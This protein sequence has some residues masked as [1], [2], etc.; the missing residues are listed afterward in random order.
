M[1]SNSD[2]TCTVPGCTKTDRVCMR[3]AGVPTDPEAPVK[4]FRDEE[5]G[6]TFCEAFM[7]WVVDSKRF[8]DAYNAAPQ[9][10]EDEGN[11]DAALTPTVILSRLKERVQGQDKACQSIASAIYEQRKNRQLR[12]EHQDLLEELDLEDEDVSKANIF[13]P[14]PT[15]CGKTYIVK[16]VAKLVNEPS[17]VYRGTAGLTAAG[18]VGGNVEDIA[19]EYFGKVQE[20]LEKQGD[21]KAADPRY[22]ANWINTNGGIIAIDE[23]DKIAAS[24]GTGKDVGGQAVQD[25]LLTFMEGEEVNITVPAPGNPRGVQVTIDTTHIQFILM[26]AFSPAGGGDKTGLSQKPLV[27]II[28]ARKGSGGSGMEGRADASGR[29]EDGNLYL[30]AKEED[31]VKFGFKPE[32]VG[33]IMGYFAPLRQL[34]EEDLVRILTHVRGNPVAVEKAR[35]SILGSDRGEAGFDLIFTD[36]ALAAIAKKAAK[37]GTGA[38]GLKTVLRQTL[39]EIGFLAPDMVGECDEILIVPKV[40]ETEGVIITEGEEKTFRK[41]GRRKLVPVDDGPK[42]DA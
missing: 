19:E 9:G 10:D 13:M 5:S 11:T 14:G 29:I 18:Y 42:D 28:K 27:D 8:I 23:V 36:D 22:V 35:Y 33:R 31:F 32:F 7:D 15:G 38:R 25:R 17:Y 40:V 12:T 30:H 6:L 1:T 26:G 2:W 41:S 34:G 4:F 16:T 20:W 39:S 24:K 3:Q 21:A 37:K